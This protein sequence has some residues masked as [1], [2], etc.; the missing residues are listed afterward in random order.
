MTDYTLKCEQP[1]V[2]CRF[3]I[4]EHYEYELEI[5]L[6]LP[7]VDQVQKGNYD[8]MELWDK[9]NPDGDKY[10]GIFI[11]ED[12]ITKFEVENTNPDVQQKWLPLPMKR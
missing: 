7:E 8:L 3:I 1:T 2:K 11:S 12:T 10:D 4:K 9:Q 5:N 6:T